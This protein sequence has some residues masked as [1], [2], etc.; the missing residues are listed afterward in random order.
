MPEGAGVDG[1]SSL[2]ASGAD[3]DA[4]LAA[5]IASMPGFEGG[6]SWPGPAWEPGRLSQGGRGEPLA[7]V[8]PPDSGEE[9]LLEAL[10]DRLA[11]RLEEAAIDQG[12]DLEG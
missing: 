5:L 1:L 4:A 7:A 8:V 3:P 9:D 11:E 12:I 6:A 2:P 10:F